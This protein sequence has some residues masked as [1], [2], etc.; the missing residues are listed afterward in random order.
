MK[1]ERNKK[2]DK[3]KRKM[4]ERKGIM[5]ERDE[6]KWMKENDECKW[7]KLIWMH[8]AYPTIARKFSHHQFKIIYDKYMCIY[9]HILIQI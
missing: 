3:W 5:K 6:W 8:F 4:N 2:G 1:R 7:M 9:T